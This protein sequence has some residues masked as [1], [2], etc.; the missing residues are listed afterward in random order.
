M[1]DL[2][3]SARA[4]EQRQE[5]SVV[6]RAWALVQAHPFLATF[7]IALAGRV[8]VALVANN[9]FDGALI[10]PD[11]LTYHEMARAMAENDTANWDDFT[12]GLFWRTATFLLPL[13]ALYWL[14]EPSVLL[15]GLY[16][17]VLG[18]G[19]AALITVLA[20]DS[21]RRF[22]IA[23]GLILALLPSQ[24]FW[25]AVTLK[26][27]MVWL[28]YVALALF[29][30]RSTKAEGRKLL[31]YGLFTGVF[32]ILLAYTRQHSFVIACWAVALTATIGRP[33]QRAARVAGGLV[34]AI[35]LP[36]AVGFGPAGIDL[37]TGADPNQMR[38]LN[39]ENANSAFV[40]LPENLE[41]A[42]DLE[43]RANEVGGAEGD[44]LRERAAQLRGSSDGVELEGEGT[45]APSLS[46]LPRGLTAMLFEPFPWAS[47]DSKSLNLARLETIV[48][49]PVL[50]L[51]ALGLTVAWRHRALLAFPLTAGAATLVV[52]ALTEGNL[53]T[54]YRHR[55]EF[56]WAV[57]LLAGFGFARL[58]ARRREAEPATQRTSPPSA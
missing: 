21:L 39:A 43:R 34:L 10:Q 27:A 23:P 50:I 28:L 24:V 19:T 54:A 56:V 3:V 42:Q 45:L 20:K 16:V 9:L 36:W 48:W 31:A 55:G 52:Y 6:G 22:A 15:G 18:A 7:L 8:F 58:A 26:D 53:G 29:I 41:E 51:A 49:Y 12:V 4:A 40:E 11:S 44:L 2:S 46:H 33:T 37:I 57:A 1:S 30:F 35:G 25:S 32:L 5:R 47:S 38:V 13:R 17:G 14:A